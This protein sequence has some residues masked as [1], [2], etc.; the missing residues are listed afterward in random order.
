VLH[1]EDYYHNGET[2][3]DRTGLAE[4]I[5]AKQRNGPTGTVILR[6]DS[7]HVRFQNAARQGGMYQ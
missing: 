2:N 4:V 7:E 6:W 3:Y 1:R 5:V